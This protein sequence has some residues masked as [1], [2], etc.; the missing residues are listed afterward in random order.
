MKKQEILISLRKQLKIAN[1]SDKSINNYLSALGKFFDYLLAKNIVSVT[2]AVIT[3]YLYYC[4][5]DI[6]Y[7]TS[8]LKQIVA[9][10]KHFYNRILEKPIPKA[11]NIKVRRE[12]HLPEVLSLPEVQRIIKATQNLKHKTILLTI[13][14]AG[15]RL[16]ETINLKVA[17]ID[18]DRMK[19][20]IRQGKGKKDRFVMLSEKLLLTMREYFQQYKPTDY[21]FEGQKGGSY[22]SKSIQNIMKNA[23][24]IARIAKIA[25]PHTL[26]HS[27]ATHLLEQGCDIRY[28]QE[29]LGHKNLATTQ[30][31]THITKSAID[32]IKSPLDSIDF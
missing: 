20:H 2:D 19:I 32:V 16:A 14:S 29:L 15:L 10:L 23:V 24:K 22:S 3:D 12:E 18:S 9:S 4:K 21:L 26:R 11:L 30:L 6:G 28:I 13:Y 5:N 25:T 1:Y 27:F 31:Y 17:D 8:S 7:A